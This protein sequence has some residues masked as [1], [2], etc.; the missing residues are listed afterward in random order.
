V[1]LASLAGRSVA[2]P[3]AAKAAADV[4]RRFAVLILLS[5]FIGLGASR[6]NGGVAVRIS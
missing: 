2:R 3:Q 1:A 4:Y 5:H 6:K